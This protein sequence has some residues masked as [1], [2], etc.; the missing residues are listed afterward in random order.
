MVLDLSA[1]LRIIAISFWEPSESAPLKFTFFLGGVFEGPATSRASS[2]WK[3]CLACRENGNFVQ[4]K[5]LEPEG[6]V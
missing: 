2:R 5:C 6:V 4:M 3:K 1:F